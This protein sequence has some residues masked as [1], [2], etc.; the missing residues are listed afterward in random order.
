MKLKISSSKHKR[1]PDDLKPK[2]LSY[3]HFENHAADLMFAAWI[4][5]M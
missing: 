4:T 3:L 5:H 2:C 1:E